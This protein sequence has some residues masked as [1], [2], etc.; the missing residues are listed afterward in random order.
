MLTRSPNIQATLAAILTV[1]GMATSAQA[2]SPATPA[3]D[4]DFQWATI[5]HAGDATNP[6]GSRVSQRPATG[7]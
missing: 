1:V 3:P 6:A 2:A 4:Y 5:T 7:S